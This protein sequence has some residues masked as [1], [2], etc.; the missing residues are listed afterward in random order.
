MTNEL[1]LATICM[2]ATADFNRNVT[3]AETLV[4]RA[5]SLGGNWVMLPE[6][7]SYYGPY[8]KLWEHSEPE[9]D[10]LYQRFSSLAKELGIVL[11]TGTLNEKPT[12]KDLTSIRPVSEKGYKRVYNTLYIFGR[13]GE[14][15]GKYRKTHLFNLYDEQGQALFC[16][17]SGFIQGNE[18]K[19]VEID[20]FKIG[21]AICFEVRFPGIFSKLN[22]MGP[23][24]VLALP[25]A[26]TLSTGTYHW[27]TLLRARAIENL[28]YVF[29]SN[30]TGA[31]AKEPNA[32]ASSGH[33]MIIDPWGNKLADTGDIESVALSVISK[34]RIA[35]CRVKLPVAKNLRPE[36]Y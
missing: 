30:Q 19:I 31:H 21:L 5:A 12:E 33:S 7:F 1:T 35:A 2:N 14:L 9:G 17:A 3:R 8:D 28:C 10:A 18:L 11:F 20:S 23:P 32:R 16:E 34:E 27:E 13:N 6:M 24:D 4:R 36:L 22:K 26:F 25:A 15:L 29:A